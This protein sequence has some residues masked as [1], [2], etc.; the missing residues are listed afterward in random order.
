VVAAGRQRKDRACLKTGA[1][2][3]LKT[4]ASACLKTGAGACLKTGAGACLKTGAS[5]CLKTGAGGGGAV[6]VA[7]ARAGPALPLGPWR[8][9][10]WAAAG[11]RPGGRLRLRG[12]RPR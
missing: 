10:A 6:L 11:S 3:C 5:A 4:G 8:R 2:A 12:P 9:P 1:S 7:L